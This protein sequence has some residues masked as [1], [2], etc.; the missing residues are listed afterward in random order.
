MLTMLF[1]II[2]ASIIHI[3]RSNLICGLWDTEMWDDTG[4]NAYDRC[5]T[6]YE[7]CADEGE[8]CPV[9]IE[10]SIY[11]GG[12]YDVHAFWH[13]KPWTFRQKKNIPGGGI[14]CELPNFY[15]DPVPGA[16]KFCC[17]EP[18]TYD[19]DAIGSWEL[20]AD[21]NGC[22]TDRAAV[23]YSLSKG[24]KSSI[25]KS[26]SHSF[27]MKLQA[28]ISGGFTVKPP[29]PSGR[30]LQ[31][32]SA[33]LE[34]TGSIAKKIVEQTKET[35]SQ[36][37]NEKLSIPCGQRFLYQWVFRGSE[38]RSDGKFGKYES[39]T[40]YYKCTPYADPKCL[41]LDTHCI[42]RPDKYIFVPT[43][44]NWLDAQTYCQNTYGT[45]LAVINNAQEEVQAK[46][47]CESGK[48]CW[49]G[50][51]DVSTENVYVW[52][53]GEIQ[54]DYTNWADGQP[55]NYQGEEHCVE[56]NDEYFDG[57]W[58]DASCSIGL[59]PLCNAPVID[60]A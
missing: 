56:L 32:G 16:T 54:A 35:F 31:E 59:N 52:N 1:M 21:C 55:D 42:E 38:D 37:I 58:G 4:V 57:K 9:S 24:T 13:K 33:N 10:K 8:W 47:E 22:G 5:P 28:K 11:F 20:I 25:E 30:R 15:C 41:P 12:Y 34:I 26:I 29:T 36:D 45:T 46:N 40:R 27:E 2:S 60:E 53:N 39:K 44:M 51:N 7:K 17:R 48:R 50:L 43:L 49:I 14:W 6:G 18:L 23:T 19:F 3:A